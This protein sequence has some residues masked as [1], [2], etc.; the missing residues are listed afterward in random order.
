MT[1]GRLSVVWLIERGML[2]HRRAARE[3]RDRMPHRPHAISKGPDKH[4]YAS[5]ETATTTD[6]TII[7]ITPSVIRIFRHSVKRRPQ[8]G[9]I[10]AL[11]L[12]DCWQSGHVDRK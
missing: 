6:A 12:M 9:H 4:D 1:L 8:C 10:T 5:R 3:G 2:H 7:A 11:R